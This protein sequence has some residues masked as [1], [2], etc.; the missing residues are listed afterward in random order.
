MQGRYTCSMGNSVYIVD[1][2]IPR[3]PASKRVQFY[4]HLRKMSI[5]PE[6]STRSVFRTGEKE[7]AEALYWLVVA[8]G[9]TIS[10][11][12]GEQIFLT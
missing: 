3:E 12:K 7:L 5:E 9:G 2:D 6:Y 11:Y 4:R 10:M 8:H 1:Y